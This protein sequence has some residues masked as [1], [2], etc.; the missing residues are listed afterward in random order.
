VG[1]PQREVSKE[2]QELKVMIS[3]R[4]TD[5]LRLRDQRDQQAAEINERKQRDALKCQSLEQLK[6]L[7]ESRSASQLILPVAKAPLTFISVYFLKY[8]SESLRFN[9][10]SGGVERSLPRMQETKSS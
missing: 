5:S 4:D 2:N 8:R 1:F 6:D 9:R 3:K 10:R 7:A